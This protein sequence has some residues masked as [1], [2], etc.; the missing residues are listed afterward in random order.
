[1][2]SK[3]VEGLGR[4]NRQYIRESRERV[5]IKRRLLILS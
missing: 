5:S 4:A 2:M 3:Y 1:M